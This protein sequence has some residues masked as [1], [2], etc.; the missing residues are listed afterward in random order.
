MELHTIRVVD[1]DEKNRQE[2]QN[3][4]H[5]INKKWNG[6]IYIPTLINVDKI[7]NSVK[8][9]YKNLTHAKQLK[10]N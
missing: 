6:N 1:F 7:F 8:K 2:T 5:L 9:Y 3:I 10:G 4:N